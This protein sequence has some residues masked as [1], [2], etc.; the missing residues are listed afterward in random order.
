MAPAHGQHTDEVIRELGR[1][2]AE[3]AELR[4]RGVLA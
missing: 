1:T 4:A 3:V 2:Q